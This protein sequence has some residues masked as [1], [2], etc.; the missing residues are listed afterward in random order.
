M[1][2]NTNIIKFVA[3]NIWRICFAL[4]RVSEYV[5]LKANHAAAA[6][7]TKKVQNILNMYLVIIVVD[8][9]AILIYRQEDS[10]NY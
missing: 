2:E 8:Q 4:K 5:F 1:H 9:T 10:D 6:D 3:K 7:F